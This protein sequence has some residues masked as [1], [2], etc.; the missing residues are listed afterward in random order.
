MVI[1]KYTPAHA[2]TPSSQALTCL[3]NCRVRSTNPPYLK[4][5]TQFPIKSNA[6]KLIHKKHLR[7]IRHLV[8]RDKANP[9]KPDLG[10]NTPPARAQ[11]LPN[12]LP[13][14]ELRT[15]LQSQKQTQTNPIRRRTAPGVNYDL[16]LGPAPKVRFT[17]NRWHYKCHWFWDYGGGDLVNDGIHH[18]DLAI[19]GMGVDKKYPTDIVTS[20]GQ[21][22]YDDDHETPDTQTII[23]V[24]PKVQIIYEMRLWTPYDMG[25]YGNATVF[26]GTEGYMEGSTAVRGDEKI[27]VKPQDYGIEPV[28]DIRENFITA[29][30]NDDPSMLNSPIDIGAVSVIMC[31]LGNIGTRLGNASLTYDPAARKITK[32]SRDIN[33]ANA[34]LTRQYRKPYTLAYTG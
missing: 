23:Y 5:Q 12:L 26:Y 17:K 7:P 9:N 10:P 22:W 11:N 15:P 34:M 6:P 4:K 1:T 2:Q 16:W 28:E 27:E 25:G 21:L 33:K 19:W 29:V 8:P 18:L 30:R 20:G 14:N 32:C 3:Y 13:H 31:N 24:Y